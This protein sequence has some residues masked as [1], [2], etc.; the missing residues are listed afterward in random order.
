MI[1][2]IVAMER[3]HPIPELYDLK[4]RGIQVLSQTNNAPGKLGN[5]L[6]LFRQRF[7]RC[8]TALLGRGPL[9]R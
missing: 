4:E 5:L 2:V 1:V 6:S 9:G 8:S 3:A 7:E